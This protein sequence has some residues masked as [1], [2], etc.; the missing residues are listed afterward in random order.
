MYMD[1]IMY[2]NGTYK[3]SKSEE[4]IKKNID[5]SEYILFDI[6]TFIKGPVYTMVK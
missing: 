5:K 4:K 6:S 3:K 2:P 1:I